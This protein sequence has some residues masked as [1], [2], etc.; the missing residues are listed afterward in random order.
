MKGFS[1]H[2]VLYQYQGNSAS[3]LIRP[4]LESECFSFSLFSSLVNKANKQKHAQTKQYNFDP[5]LKLYV[6]INGMQ[7]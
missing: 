4:I 6:L 3:M 5:M 1:D 7:M 2:K